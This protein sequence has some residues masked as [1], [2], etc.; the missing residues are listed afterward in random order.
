[1]DETGDGRFWQLSH[2]TQLLMGKPFVMLKG[3]KQCQSATKRCHK[4]PVIVVFA[5]AK[6]TV[7][8]IQ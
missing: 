1:M 2:L 5:L 8:S 3:G 7:Y 4:L 6:R